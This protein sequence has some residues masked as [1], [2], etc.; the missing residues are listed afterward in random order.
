MNPRLRR[1][2]RRVLHRVIVALVC[3]AALV[4]L[5]TIV[6]SSLRTNPDTATSGWWTVL[7]RPLVTLENYP[8]AAE[9]M[10]LPDSI[11]ATL[12]IAVPTTVLTVLLAAFGGYVVT[13]L[14]FR[15]RVPVMLIAIVVIALPPQ[16]LVTPLL[17]LFATLGINGSFLAVWLVQVTFTVPYGLLLV[18]G[19]LQYIPTETLE[20]ARIDGASELR[21][22]LRIVLPLSAPILASLGIL[23]FLWSW[24]DLITPLVFL[25]SLSADAPVTVQVAGLLQST[26]P[27][28]DN[29]LSAAGVI[30]AI[31]PVAIVLTLQRYFVAGITSGAGK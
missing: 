30:S 24:N 5:L 11:P 1:L 6:A 29:V 9:L 13:H 20:A 14:P 10:Q 7:L 26:G 22:F 28:M 23:Q 18:N 17:Q 15:F 12:A 27:S 31:I 2:G 25:G 16:A 19:Y 3:L 8:A 4:P 21:I